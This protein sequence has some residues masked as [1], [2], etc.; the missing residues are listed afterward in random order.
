MG[1]AMRFRTARSRRGVAAGPRALFGLAL[2]LCFAACSAFAPPRAW[3]ATWAAPRTAAC[4][5]MRSAGSVILREASLP[6][7]LSRLLRGLDVPAAPAAAEDPVSVRALSSEELA[8]SG[9]GSKLDLIAKLCT[10]GVFGE[11]SVGGS[12]WVLKNFKAKYGEDDAAGRQSVMLVAENSRGDIVGCVGM[13]MMLLTDDGLAWWT[14]PCAIVKKRPFVSDLVVD[15]AYRQRGLGRSLLLKCH[16]LVTGEWAQEIRGMAPAERLDLDV[17]SIFLKVDAE[18]QAA[19]R[20]YRRMGYKEVAKIPEELMVP[21]S[22]TSVQGWPV[23]NIYMQRDMSRGVC[24]FNPLA[25]FKAQ[26]SVRI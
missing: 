23:L 16:E 10:R 14:N 21:K 1:A 7:S 24:Q 5:R 2:A 20:L 26:T 12:S 19:V 9:E 22:P 8:D 3:D 15:A 25:A 11:A 6:R 18:N 13:E 4:L 17:G